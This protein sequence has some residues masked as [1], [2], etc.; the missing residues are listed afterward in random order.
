MV[1]QI[2]GFPS[3]TSHSRDPKRFPDIVREPAT[4][5]VCLLG[6]EIRD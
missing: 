2:F 4:S 6:I 1:L 5:I 3:K